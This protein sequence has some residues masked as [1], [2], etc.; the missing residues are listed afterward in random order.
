MKK[1]SLVFLSAMLLVSAFFAGSVSSATAQESKILE[2]DTMVGTTAGLTGDQSLIPLR[3]VRGGGLPWTLTSAHGELKAS[4]K[5]EI[6]VVGLVLAAG[7]NAGSNPSAVFRALVSCLS[8]NGSVQN[9]LTDAF[10]ATTGPAS[11]GG[12]NS[13]IETTVALPQPCIAPIV[14]VT[15]N[16][17]SRFAV[18]GN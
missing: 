8:S 7:A 9:I 6:E 5:L 18:T 12:G 2:F 3:G 17:G 11:L 10:P 15:N 14:F 1:V 4:G 13:K 16:G